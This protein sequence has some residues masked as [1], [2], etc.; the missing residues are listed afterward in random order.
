MLYKQFRKNLKLY[1]KSSKRKKLKKLLKSNENNKILIFK[2][3]KKIL[4]I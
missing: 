4:Q 3:H 1:K 2:I